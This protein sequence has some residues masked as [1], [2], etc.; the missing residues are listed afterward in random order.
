MGA[1]ARPAVHPEP[2]RT[3]AMRSIAHS[4]NHTWPRTCVA[5]GRVPDLSG[6]GFVQ[7][8]LGGL[9]FVH[10]KTISL[11]HSGEALD[12]T[13]LES[14]SQA[15][16]TGL[17]HAGLPWALVVLGRGTDLAVYLGC[18]SPSAWPTPHGQLLAALFP[19]SEIAPGL[20]HDDLARGLFRLDWVAALTGNPSLPPTSP[21]DRGASGD[22]ALR[23]QIEPLLRAMT[24]S[25]AAYVVIGRPV[26]D[27]EISKD[28]ERLMREERELVSSYQRRGSAEESNQP[29]AR[30]R[31]R[32]RK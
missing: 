22:H 13:A 17:H 32:S 11:S 21:N 10:V 5:H 24:G 16:L 19:G 15:F 9:A 20:A 8:A 26:P 29:L 7:D 14:D 1:H 30:H 25:V 27:E 28:L 23:G 12:T 18:P 2:T 3:G 6:R 31:R 4:Q